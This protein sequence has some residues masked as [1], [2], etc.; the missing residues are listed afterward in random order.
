MCWVCACASA[1]YSVAVI[2]SSPG[3]TMRNVISR[4]PWLTIA[5]M[6]ASCSIWISAGILPLL[7]SRISS[8]SSS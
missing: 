6:T 3:A 4:V 1:G 7:P 5:H 8:T 2:S